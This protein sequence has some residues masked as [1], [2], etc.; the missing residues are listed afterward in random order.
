MEQFAS[1]VLEIMYIVIGLQ[2]LYTAYRVFNDET[3]PTRIGTTLFWAILGVLFVGG[4]Y[5]PNIIN[6]VLV[7]IIG[8]ITLFKQVSIGEIKATPEKEVKENADNTGN[9]I[10]LPVM[11]LAISSLLIAQIFPALSQS[12]LGIGALIGTI[13][14]LFTIRRGPKTLLPESDRMIQQVSTTG[15]LPQLLGALGTVF[16]AAGVGD[17]VSG[18]VQGVIPAESRFWGVLVY[19]LGMVLFTMVMG[20]AFAAFTVI[21]LGIGVPFVFSLGADPIIAG[22]LAMTAGFCGT[23]MT[24]MAGNFNA[25]P[26]A[27]LEMKSEFGVIKDQVP[28]ALIMIVVHV[29]LMYYLPFI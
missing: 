20:N 6:G 26:V 28:F 15:I 22:A 12:V 23:L 8:V 3:N 17:V 2:L 10:F 19:V 11:T 7:L 25:L 21:T 24:P 1:T 18:L 4:S 27:L 16:T 5:I 14:L 13:T 29:V 9:G